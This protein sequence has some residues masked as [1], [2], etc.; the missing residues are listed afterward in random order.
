MLNFGRAG[1]GR[2]PFVATSELN[3]CGLACL[4]A[5]SAFFDGEAG[6][7]ELRQLA[8]PSGRGE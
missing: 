7:A 5:I 2:V 8:V 3:E 6:L 1:R 4:A